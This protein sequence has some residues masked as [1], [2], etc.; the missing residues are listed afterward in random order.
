MK[1]IEKQFQVASAMTN[2]SHRIRNGD[3]ILISQKYPSSAVVASIKLLLSVPGPVIDFCAIKFHDFFLTFD[4]E[5]LVIRLE[6]FRSFPKP[7]FSAVGDNSSDA[8][9]S[10]VDDGGMAVSGEFPCETRTRIR[11]E[12]SYSNSSVK[13]AIEFFDI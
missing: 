7:K 2:K 10:V 5:V 4:K 8:I 11:S 3:A 1:G 9:G 6:Y 13:G 12:F